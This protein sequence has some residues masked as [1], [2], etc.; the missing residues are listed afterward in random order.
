MDPV[1]LFNFP[2]P[3][4]RSEVKPLSINPLIGLQEEESQP[5]KI[6][7]LYSERAGPPKNLLRTQKTLTLSLVLI[8]SK[9]LPEREQ[10]FCASNKTVSQIPW[11]PQL[12][13][14]LARLAVFFRAKKVRTS[15]VLFQFLH[16]LYDRVKAERR[17]GTRPGPYG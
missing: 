10:W 1:P 15:G 14:F 11:E 2:L 12:P 3:S 17:E 8:G 9:P 13:N 7:S 6:Y 4:E 5:R 16:F